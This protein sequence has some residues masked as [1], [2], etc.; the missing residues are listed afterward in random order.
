[1]RFNDRELVQISLGDAELEGRLNHRRPLSGNFSQKG[2]KE[3]WFKLKSNLLFYF[4]IS[5]IGKIYEKQPAG[6]FVLE[7]SNIQYEVCNGVPFA[8]S[9]TFRDEP[10]RKHL[11]SGRSEDYIH[12]W[13]TAMKQATYGH[14]RSQLVILQT[15]INAKTGKDPLLMYPHNRGTVRDF[16]SHRG[17]KSVG[18]TSSSFQCH[19][20]QKV[21]VRKDEKRTFESHLKRIESNL[22]QSHIQQEEQSVHMPPENLIEL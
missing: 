8:F 18:A 15:K 20:R 12:Q 14:W 6:V 19:L 22:C 21:E 16:Q 7:N 9:V 4:R 5:E 3:R 1:M 2:F 10:D 17:N 13:V 11:F